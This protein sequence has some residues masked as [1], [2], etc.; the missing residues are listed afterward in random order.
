[1]APRASDVTECIREYLT[2]MDPW[3]DGSGASPNG[4]KRTDDL[5]AYQRMDHDFW[6]VLQPW[7]ATSLSLSKQGLK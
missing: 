1:M 3:V 4:W 7:L 5:S 2:E 6:L